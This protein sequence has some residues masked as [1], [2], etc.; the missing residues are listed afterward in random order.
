ML[1]LVMFMLVVGCTAQEKKAEPAKKVVEP[2]PAISGAA[3]AKVE[4]KKVEVKT[5]DTAVKVE[6]DSVKVE[7]KTKTTEAKTEVKT[8]T[9]KTTET[10]T[11]GN[12]IKVTD[13]GF[14]PK[15]LKVKVGDTVEWQNVRVGKINKALII[16]AQSCFD[17]K[18]PILESGKSFKYT[19]KKADTCTI[20]EA[21]TTTQVGKVVV[22]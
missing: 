15:E 14:E 19:F 1:V 12:V 6:G 10:K 17:V 18:S 5:E 22:E 7:T 16:G 21:I 11:S 9:T 13:K 2:A 4:E 8:E 20:V 3:T